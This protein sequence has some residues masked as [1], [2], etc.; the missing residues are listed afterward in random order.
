VR[1]RRGADEGD[2][3]AV[4][5]TA[6]QLVDELGLDLL[7]ETFALTGEGAQPP[8]AAIPRPSPRSDAPGRW[9]PSSA[10]STET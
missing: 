10:A 7:D 2:D 8:E 5:P 4:R 3:A 1:I 9:P 6:R